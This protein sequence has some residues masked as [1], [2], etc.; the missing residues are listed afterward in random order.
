MVEAEDTGEI[1]VEQSEPEESAD[2]PGVTFTAPRDP[3]PDVQSPPPA[4]S[5]PLRLTLRETADEAG[6][7]RRLSAVFRA[8]QSQ[9]GTDPV[10]L[11]IHTRDGETIELA[12]PTVRMDE[13]LRQTLLGALE[14]G[15]SVG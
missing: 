1:N 3:M 14:A 15:E 2:A 6:D 13:A 10:H 9:P 5:G 4:P 7:Q 8:L 11:T 12:L